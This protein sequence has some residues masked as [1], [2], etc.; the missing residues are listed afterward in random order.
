V[1]GGPSVPYRKEG[2]MPTKLT[3]SPAQRLAVYEQVRLHLSTVSDLWL[4]LE[5]NHDY[6]TAKRLGREFSED[7]RLLD[8]LG[9]NPED[10]RPEFELTMPDADLMRVLGRLRGE[11]DGGLNPTGVERESKEQEERVELGFRRA[12]D[13]CDD[14]LAQLG[15]RGGELA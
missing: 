14:L 13:A 8:D 5:R 7:S 15:V 3:I 2:T 12:R 1:F 9:W 4:A 6:E 11:A 10:V